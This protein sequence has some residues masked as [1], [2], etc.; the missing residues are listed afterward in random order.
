M[1]DPNSEWKSKMVSWF[2]DNY[3]DPAN[4][5]PHD[6]G[7]GGYQYV[8]GGPYD[9]HEELSEHFPDASIDEIE[10]AVELIEQNG[11]E[12]VKKGQY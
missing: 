1:K 5:V 12:W 11:G 7:E 2:F 3:A 9:A 6:S 10:E 8:L 4:G